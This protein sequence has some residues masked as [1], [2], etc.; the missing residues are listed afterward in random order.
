MK[1][2]LLT[3]PFNT[4]YGG[5]LQAY[6]LQTVLERM[7]HKV[8]VFDTPKKNS[9]PPLWK[10]PL[11]F[12]KRIL[13][14]SMGRIDRIFIERYNNRMRP[15]LAKEDSHQLFDSLCKMSNRRRNSFSRFLAYHYEFHVNCDFA[16]RYSP[17]HDVLVEL[18]DLVKEEAKS[19]VSIEKWS[20]DRL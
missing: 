1:I 4:N 19:K 20:Y 7:G 8:V 15:I 16:D 12:A 6:A 5:I 11:S 2:G 14:K 13:L 10:L 18:R 17:D 9:L 3:L